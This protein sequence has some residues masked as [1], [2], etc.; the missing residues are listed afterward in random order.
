[1]FDVEIQEIW[2][3]FDVFFFGK[4]NLPMANAEKKTWIPFRLEIN[5]FVNV[6]S[7]FLARLTMCMWTKWNINAIVYLSRAI[8]YCSFCFE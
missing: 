2:E 6:T 5:Y 4:C 8:D 3:N 1:M 7:F